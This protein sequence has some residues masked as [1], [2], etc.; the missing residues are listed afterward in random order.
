MK[1]EPGATSTTIKEKFD[2]EGPRKISQ[3]AKPVQAASARPQSSNMLSKQRK[4][5]KTILE[6]QKRQL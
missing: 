4:A 3:N 1:V 2:S 5:S 6:R